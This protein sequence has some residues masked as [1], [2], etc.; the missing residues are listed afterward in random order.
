MTEGMWD[1]AKEKGIISASQLKEALQVQ[2]N[3]GKEL[4]FCLFDI[5]ALDEDKWIEF[6]INDYDCRTIDLDKMEIDEEAVRII[7]ARVAKSLLIIPVRKARD[8][9]AIS[10]INPLNQN[11]IKFISHITDYEILPFASKKSQIE[12]AIEVF[13]AGRGEGKLTFFPLLETM[14]GIPLVDEFSFDKFVVDR[15]NEFAYSLALAVAKSY[16]DEYNP[17]FIWGDVGLGKT[18]LLNAVGNYVKND[19]TER[20]FCYTSAKK[21]VNRLLTAIQENTLKEF[22]DKYSTI[23]VLLLDDVE[24][25]IGR[26]RTQEEFFHI[27]DLLSHRKCQIVLTSDRPPEKLTELMKRLT[28]RFASGVVVEIKEPVFETKMAILKKHVGD[29]KISDDIIEYIAKEGPGSVRGVLGLLHKIISLAEYKK[30]EITLTLAK[31]ALGLKTE[32]EE[33]VTVKDNIETDKN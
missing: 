18:H 10:M 7:P 2:R 19:S 17:F 27:F 15:G 23:D 9:I 11:I 6:L 25:L 12:K 29:K 3:E 32:D 28:S 20:S 5:G 24:F 22:Q 8:A 31:E 1:K 21:F 13:Y 14:E 16:N 33:Q 30:E 4:E 26:E